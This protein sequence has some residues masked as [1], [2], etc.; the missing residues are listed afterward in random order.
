MAKNGRG[1]G[2]GR[3]LTSALTPD[4]HLAILLYLL[5]LIG[6]AQGCRLSPKSIFG[7]VFCLGIG[8]LADLFRI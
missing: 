4:E 1:H 6:G 5:Q 7:A 3:A 2:L 8:L